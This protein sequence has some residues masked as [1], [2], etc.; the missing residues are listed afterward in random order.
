MPTCRRARATVVVLLAIVSAAGV[1]L[2]SRGET[3]AAQRIE[4]KR[5]EDM[6]P[7]LMYDV[8]TSYPHDRE[9]FTQGLI[10]RDGFLY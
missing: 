8:V 10:Y 1:L 5:G 6:A 3:H 2:V 7:L 9:A 4:D